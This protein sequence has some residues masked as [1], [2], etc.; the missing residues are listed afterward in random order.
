MNV[1]E[2]AEMIL[3]LSTALCVSPEEVWDSKTDEETKTLA[4][5]EEV[6]KAVAELQESGE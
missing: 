5:R 1:K 3:G 4:D 6:L 2:I